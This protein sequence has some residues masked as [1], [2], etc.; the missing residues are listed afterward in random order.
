MLKD[1]DTKKIKRKQSAALE[2]GQTLTLF[3]KH[4]EL[5][6][7]VGPRRGWRIIAIESGNDIDS[8][9]NKSIICP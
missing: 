9:P 7:P 4:Y 5:V 8:L 6:S 1:Y 2:V 3:G